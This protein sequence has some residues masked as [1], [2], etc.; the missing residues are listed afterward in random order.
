MLIPGHEDG[1]FWFL[2]TQMKAPFHFIGTGQLF[3]KGFLKI[4]CEGR[5]FKI[6]FKP[7]KKFTYLHID[8]LVQVYNI[9]PTAMDKS[10][11]G[12]DDPG[13]VLTQYKNGSFQR[14]NAIKGTKLEYKS[15]KVKEGTDFYQIPWSFWDFYLFGSQCKGITAIKYR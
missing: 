7:H 4:R 15:D 11:N 12:T 14:N 13:L 9:A 3:F 5:P 10:R 2:G 8:M 1:H 6:T